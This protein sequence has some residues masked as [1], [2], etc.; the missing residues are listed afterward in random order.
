MSRWKSVND[1]ISVCGWKSFRLRRN[2][3]TSIYKWKNSYTYH[4]KILG[5]YLV[6]LTQDVLLIKKDFNVKRFHHVNSRIDDQTFF[7]TKLWDNLCSK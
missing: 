4:I 2:K 3:S 1:S 7:L 6:C 5:E